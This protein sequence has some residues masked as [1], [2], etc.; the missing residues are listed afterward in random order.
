MCFIMYNAP[1][2][3]ASSLP[4]LE[5]R[6]SVPDLVSQLWISTPPPYSHVARQ[7]KSPTALP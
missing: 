3:N 7:P 2:R 4:S 6:L 5:S 1:L